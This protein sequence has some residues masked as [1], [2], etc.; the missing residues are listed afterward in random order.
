MT[1]HT[2][3]FRPKGSAGR[4]TSGMLRASVREGEMVSITH[5][6]ASFAEHE[7]MTACAEAV[8]E[9]L[10]LPYRTVVLCTGDLGFGL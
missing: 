9:A 7:R 4:D 2:Q 5:P 8:L 10:E 1:S 6:E 3:C